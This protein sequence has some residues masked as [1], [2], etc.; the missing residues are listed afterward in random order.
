[1]QGEIIEASR[2]R[3]S[4]WD[5]PFGMSYSSQTISGAYTVSPQ[6]PYMIVLSAAVAQNVTMYNPASATPP[7]SPNV[8]WCHEIFAAGAGALT[9]KGTQGTTVGT[10]PA[11]KRGEIV[12]NPMASPQDWLV[13]LSA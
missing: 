7:V 12:F 5:G 9:I 1:M 6:A 11:G 4:M 2:L 10:I 13:F 3:K 8:M